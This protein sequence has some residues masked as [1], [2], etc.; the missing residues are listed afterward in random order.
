MKL[1]IQQVVE[2]F[3]VL[4]RIGM[5][6]MPIKVAYT[7][8]R[9]IRLLTPEFTDWD[10][11]RTELITDKYGVKDEKGNFS[12]PPEK[13]K[14]F[15][16]EMKIVSEVEVDLDVHTLSLSEFRSDIAPIDLMVLSWMF[17]E[18]TLV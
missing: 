1:T 17:T 3:Q 10:K 18:D 11:K 4:S 12:V 5:E 15:Q 2:G 7:I 6:K 9:N 8:Q 16:D 14:D 13:V